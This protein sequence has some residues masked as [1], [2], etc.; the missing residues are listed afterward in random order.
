MRW[1]WG[2]YCHVLDMGY[3]ERMKGGSGMVRI[4][5]WGKRKWSFFASFFFFFLPGP[6]AL[7]MGH[8]QSIKAKLQC[9]QQ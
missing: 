6:L 5:V 9:F 3:S 1:G 7:F 2:L 8:K 4:I